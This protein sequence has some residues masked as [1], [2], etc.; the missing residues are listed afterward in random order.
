MIIP[1]AADSPEA[2]SG[3]E[4]LSNAIGSAAILSS[5]V[6]GGR[7][8]FSVAGDAAPLLG[9]PAPAQAR[10]GGRDPEGLFGITAPPSLQ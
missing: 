8:K 4:G 2:G 7:A 5:W 10:R 6:S 9:T 1:A 3:A